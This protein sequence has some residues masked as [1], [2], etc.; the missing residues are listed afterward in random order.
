MKVANIQKL[1]EVFKGVSEGKVT[2]ITDKVDHLVVEHRN[3]T[4][5]NV[6]VATE[7]ARMVYKTWMKARFSPGV[8]L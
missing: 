5:E 8:W 1:N 2:R 4:V 7:R 6:S 3:G